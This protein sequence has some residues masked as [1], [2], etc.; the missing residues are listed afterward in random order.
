M[1]QS[2][3]EVLPEC[4]TAFS[5]IRLKV[6]LLER[7]IRDHRNLIDKLTEGIEKIQELNTNLARMVAI[8]DQ[9]HETHDKIEDD[10]DLDIKEIH[11]RITTV[12]REIQDRIDEVKKEIYARLDMLHRE[13]VDHVVVKSHASGNVAQQSAHNDAQVLQVLKQLERWKYLLIGIVFAIGYALDH[14]NWKFVSQLF[15]SQ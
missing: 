3:L 1:A 4:T 2:D 5:E 15:G 12:S 10:I 13:L 11:S 7:D 6:G 14:I 9:K 8:H